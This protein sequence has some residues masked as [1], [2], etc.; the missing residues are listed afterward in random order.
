L[1]VGLRAHR[2]RLALRGTPLC[3]TK[4]Y[5]QDGSARGGKYRRARAS[6]GIETL[7]LYFG[8]RNEAEE[9]VRV[10]RLS[11]RWEAEGVESRFR[12]RYRVLSFWT[13][14]PL[15]PMG[16]RGGGKSLSSPLLRPCPFGQVGLCKDHLPA[17]PASA[18]AK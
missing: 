8:S 11:C 17:G 18:G 10:S 4:R 5:T 1:Y 16:G 3:M 2:G 13:G 9:Q 15:Q 14:G 6:R 7:R 12:A